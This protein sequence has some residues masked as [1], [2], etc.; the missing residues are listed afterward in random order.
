MRIGILTYHRSVNYGAYLQSYALQKA[1]SKRIANSEVEIIDYHSRRAKNEE[2]MMI[3]RDIKHGNMWFS[4]RLHHM[5]SVEQQKLPLSPDRLL[6]DNLVKFRTKFFNKYDIIVAGS[7]QIWRLNSFRGFPNAYWLPGE[8]K[9]HKMS[10]AASS[11][12]NID[13]ID[14]NTRN[15][16]RDMLNSF[17]YIGVRDV[18]TLKE[19]EKVTDNKIWINCDPVFLH[20]FSEV[21]M[22]YDTI[23]KNRFGINHI[24]KPIIGF[25]TRDE[26]AIESIIDTLGD[27]AE[28]VSIYIPHKKTKNSPSLSPFEFVSL[29]ENLDFLVTSYFHGLCFAIKGNTPVIA[30]E[31]RPGENQS[32]SK[33]F[34]LLNTIG[35][36]DLY[37]ASGSES[38]I[39]IMIRNI[40]TEIHNRFT[41]YI[42]GVEKLKSS[43]ESFFIAMQEI[44]NQYDN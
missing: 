9:S 27:S 25:M 38:Y 23:L 15:A 28:Y 29:I 18:V 13:T 21:K 6:S 16:I 34:D 2:L 8:M 1:I 41:N 19:L 36:Q 26:H 3:A 17:S 33:M 14:M 31:K 4:L 42:T 43:S 32:N 24:N 30:L 37:L 35:R 44:C 12:S 10:Y 7:D 40:H 20:E 22:D 5:F 39:D 11:R